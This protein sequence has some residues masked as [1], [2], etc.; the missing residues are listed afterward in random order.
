EVRPG[1]NAYHRL[2]EMEWNTPVGIAEACG[3]DAVFVRAAFEAV[4][5]FDGGLI[6]GEEPELCVRLR[7]RGNE[8]LRIDHDMTLHDV[9]MSRFGQWWARNV[10]AGYAFAAGSARHGGGSTGHW[11]RQTRRVWIWAVVLPVLAVVL[12]WPT[13]GWSG[14]LLLGYGMPLRGAYVGARRKGT[15]RSDAALYSAA[16]LISKFAELRG[17]LRF[18]SERRTGTKSGLIEYKSSGSPAPRVSP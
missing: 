8:I 17:Q 1:R 15:S 13:G 9:D 6:A 10:R 11:K 2:A 14:L 7:E 3:G 4:G 16:C 18:L 12:L 5:G